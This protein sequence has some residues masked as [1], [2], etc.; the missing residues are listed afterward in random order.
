MLSDK[1]LSE[2]GDTSDRI[3]SSDQQF[4]QSTCCGA[5]H[6]CGRPGVCHVSETF[7]S[8]AV[9]DVLH[10]PSRVKGKSLHF[11]LH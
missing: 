4:N 8:P 2:D 7:T 5:I 11:H 9:W 6:L 10:A 1:D 3:R